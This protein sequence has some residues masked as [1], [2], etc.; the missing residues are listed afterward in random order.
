MKAKSIL[1]KT[2]IGKSGLREL[3]PVTPLIDLES[4]M[5]D[6]GIAAPMSTS[7]AP[8]PSHQELFGPGDSQTHFLLLC[9][10]SIIPYTLR[11]MCLF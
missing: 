8:P 7:P 10:S 5:V 11:A 9:L 1:D 2:M 6:E 4:A 3:E